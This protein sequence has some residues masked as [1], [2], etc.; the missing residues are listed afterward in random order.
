MSSSIGYYNYRQVSNIVKIYHDLRKN[1]FGDEDI[2][3]LLGEIQTCCEKNHLFGSL[4]FFDG[5]YT[6][7]FKNV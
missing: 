1:G 4:S 6:N 3:L 7:I 2:L 5:D